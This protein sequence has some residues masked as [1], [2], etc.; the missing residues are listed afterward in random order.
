MQLIKPKHIFHKDSQNSASIS[1]H[2]FAAYTAFIGKDYH[3]SI[4]H[5]NKIIELEPNI[6]VYAKRAA[7]CK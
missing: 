2:D 7:A 4:D 3:Q 6:D 1:D 5:L